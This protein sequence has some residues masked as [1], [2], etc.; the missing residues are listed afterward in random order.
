MKQFY[1]VF[2]FI[3]LIWLAS[4]GNDKN[5]FT[6]IGDIKNMPDQKV[7]LE[8]LGVNDIIVVDSQKTKAGKFE[9]SA[10][11]PEPGLYRVRFEHNGIEQSQFLLLSV[12]K[13]TLRVN[14]D[15]SQLEEYTVTGSGSSESLRGFLRSVRENIRDFNTMGVVMDSLQAQGNDSMLTMARNDLQDMNLKFTQLVERYADST[16]YLPNAIFAARMLNPQVE[17]AYLQEFV[18]NLDRRFPNSKSVKE[19]TAAVTQVLSKQNAPQQSSGG[20]QAGAQ[21]P[22]ISLSTADGKKISL[23]SLKGKYVLIDFWASWCR[24]CR[25]EN[26]NV[27]AAYNKFKDKNFTILGVSLDNDKDKWQQAIQSDGLTWTQVSDLKGW[28]SIPARDY[29]VEAIPSNFLVDPSGK[30]I[31][32]NLRGDALETKLTEVLK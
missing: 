32:T 3:A 1:P 13:G 8:E 16:R 20:L 2:L 5:K 4:C 25:A 26:P 24:P 19:F 28:E 7:L 18:H 6:V 12:E 15:W 14:G 22:E 23:S 10:M 31:A 21:A 17:K 30:I 29:A 9:L 27:V 11:A